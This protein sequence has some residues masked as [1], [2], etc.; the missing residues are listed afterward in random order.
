MKHFTLIPALLAL[1]FAGNAF[2]QAGGSY[3][4]GL[5]MVRSG[6]WSAA[7]GEFVPLAEE[8]HAA[9]QFSVGLIHHLGRGVRQ[10]LEEAYSW[11]KKSAMQEH[12]PAVNNIGMMYLNGEY[13][14]QNREVAFKL[15]LKASETHAQ[16][17]DNLAQCHEKGW[18]TPQ[19]GD[20]AI[21]MYIKAGEQGY[22]LGWHHL[23]QLYEQGR[24]GVPADLDKA[25][26]WYIKAA[27]KSFTKSRRKLVNLGRLPDHLKK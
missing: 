21:A 27:E 24:A 23:A 11:Y 4:Q 12:P 1:L 15:F 26:E 25:V 22:I 19:D 13:V 8:G 7:L 9:S 17:K 10:D 6:Q 16:A 3:E 18:G 2:A 20:K 14:A 5:K